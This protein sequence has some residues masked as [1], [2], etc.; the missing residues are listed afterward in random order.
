MGSLVAFEALGADL[1]GIPHDL[2]GLD[3]N[4]L[5]VKVD[6]LTRAG[7]KVKMIYTI[8]DFHNRRTHDELRAS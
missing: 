8:P 2:E 6:E 5:Q 7:K 3:I 1:Q 4:K